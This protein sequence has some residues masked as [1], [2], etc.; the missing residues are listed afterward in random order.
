VF[1]TEPLKIVPEVTE[2]VS[3]ELRINGRISC[4]SN[5]ELDVNDRDAGL[6]LMESNENIDIE[7]LNSQV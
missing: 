1:S 7:A 3:P 5:D 6:L 4:G 2:V